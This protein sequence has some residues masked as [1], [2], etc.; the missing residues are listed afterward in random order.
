RIEMDFLWGKSELLRR[1]SG[2]S[3][4]LDP[5]LLRD[6]APA[7]DFFPVEHFEIVSRGSHDV[8]AQIVE[9]ALEIR[10]RRCVC[11]TGRQHGQHRWQQPR[12]SA[13][14]VPDRHFKIAIT[15]L[16]ERWHVWQLWAPAR[17]ADSERPY[18]AGLDPRKEPGKIAEKRLHLPGHQLI[19]GAHLI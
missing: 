4:R 10:C 18:L 9:S 12:W 13:Q 17:S 14:T 6:P 11:D 15:G 1:N 7:S 2:P 19:R 8:Y 3:L 5:H 16:D